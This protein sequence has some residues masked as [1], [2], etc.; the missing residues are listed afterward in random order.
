MARKF[1]STFAFLFFF[2]SVT[3]FAQ[4]NIGYMNIE[5]VLSQL[6]ERQQIEQ[7]L[8]KLITEKQ[9]EL[10]QKAADFQSALAQYQENQDVMSEQQRKQRE[11][12]LAEMEAELN[13][14]QQSVQ[15]EVQQRR[16]ELLQPVYNRIDE[17]ISVIAEQMN[18]DFVL[19][20]STSMGENIIYFSSQQQ[21]DITQKVVDHLTK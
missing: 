16:G 4:A 10:Q 13:E 20:E 6:P 11:S 15:V 18:L 19:N 9:G 2:I 12:E 8:N 1:F 3:A 14:F 7:E 17:A 5:E 21:L